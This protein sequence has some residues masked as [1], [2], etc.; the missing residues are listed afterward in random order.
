[1][2]YRIAWSS[3]ATQALRAIPWRQAERVDAAVLRFAA[4]GEGSRFRY[5]TDAPLSWRLDVP[6]Y[7]VRL[8][9]DARE[10]LIRVWYIYR[11]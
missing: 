2:T 3:P 10:P 6:P 9:V 4:T 11:Q 1:M 8:S 7:V 5:E